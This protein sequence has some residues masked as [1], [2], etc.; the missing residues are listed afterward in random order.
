MR[1]AHEE[2]D[3]LR[4]KRLGIDTYRELVI[5]MARSAPICRSEGWAAQS[6]IQV[7]C[8][9]RSIIATLNVVTDGLLAADEAS[10]SEAAW[11]Q[12]GAHDGDLARLTQS[13]PVDSLSYL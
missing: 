11:Q 2:S 9:G 12:L 10:L 3:V 4:L 1:A 7:A 5:F 13:P 6:R 8:N